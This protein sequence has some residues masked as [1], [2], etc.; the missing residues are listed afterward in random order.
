MRIDLYATATLRQRSWSM[1]RTT[2]M[3]VALFII[4][5]GIF[6]LSQD[7]KTSAEK[8]FYENSLHY[9]SRGLA[10]WYGKEQGGLERITGLPFDGL[11]CARCHV[12]TCDA[13]HT[14][15]VDGKP[16]YSTASAQD[17]KVCEG[18]HGM[19]S[20]TAYRANPD[21]PA[22]DVHFRSGMKCLDC[23]TAREMHGDGTAYNTFQEPGAMDVSCSKCHVDLS[24]CPSSRVHGDKLDCNACHIRDLPSCYN[25]HFETRVKEGKSV[26]LPLRNLLFLINRRGRVTL[27]DVHTFVYQKK[28]MITFAPSFPHWVMKE[29]RRC[30]DCHH[31][32]LLQDIKAGVFKPVVFENGALKSI[33]GVVPVLDGLR[34]N[35]TFL[36][37]QNGRWVP[38]VD[39][40]PPILNYAGF[41]SPLSREQFDKLEEARTPA[42]QLMAHR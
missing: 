1:K 11:P 6:A 26:S 41:C 15:L 10:Y 13:C 9:T 21:D 14:K 12:R 19:D 28:T 37:Y 35:F 25:C 18:C 3:A 8:N 32:P 22:G 31:T 33:A 7:S 2:L 23:H 34:W 20:L 40:A 42:A 39:P 4:G 5:L 30:K 16:V 38:L 17:E 27:G 24:G 36:D 29:G